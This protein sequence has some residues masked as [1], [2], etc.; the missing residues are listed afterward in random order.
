MR[1]QI[2]FKALSSWMNHKIKWPWLWKI[3]RNPFLFFSFTLHCWKSSNKQYGFLNHMGLTTDPGILVLVSKHLEQG[4]CLHLFGWQL[5]S[6]PRKIRR[7]DVERNQ[8]VTLNFAGWRNQIM[9]DPCYTHRKEVNG[10]SAQGQ[11]CG[12]HRLIRWLKS[13]Q[14]DDWICSQGSVSFWWEL[15]ECSKG[16]SLAMC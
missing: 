6:G 13:K 14:V 7:T 5:R 11:C 1:V 3:N 8:T 10:G 4:L 16:H 2:P 9:P 12:L 15:I